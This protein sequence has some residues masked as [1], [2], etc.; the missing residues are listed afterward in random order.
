MPSRNDS[1]PRRR[2]TSSAERRQLL[3]FVEGRRTEE[4]YIVHW[5][6]QYRG[7]IIV[8]VDKFHGSPLSLVKRAV[9]RQR[10]SVR[11]AKRGKGKAFDEIWCVFDIDEHPHLQQAIALAQENGISLAISNPCIEL[12]FIL[13]F[14]DQA[15]SIDR[16]RAQ[17]RSEELLHCSK[18]LTEQ[19]LAA[20]VSEHDKAVARAK[21]LDN[22]H[23]GDGSEDG[24]NPSS[25]VWK[26]V[27][28]IRQTQP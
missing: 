3:V 22:K 26:I 20:L 19:A 5:W 23:R 7:S 2:I 4:R 16:H 24:S 6:R 14:E 8:N 13:H 12:W 1:R 27:D 21:Q 18:N 25:S 9:E 15:A 10:E 28:S 11:E 17:H